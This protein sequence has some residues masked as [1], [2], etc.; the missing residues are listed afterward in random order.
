MI[1]PLI[2][3]VVITALKD[4]Y[5]DIKRHQSDRAV[6]YSQTRVLAG[7]D[8]HNRNATR[9]KSK[10]FVRGFVPKFL[11]PTTKKKR[12]NPGTAQ[13]EMLQRAAPPE[14][15]PTRDP[16]P[17]EQ[18]EFDGIEY[19]DGEAVEGTEHHGLFHLHSSG[20]PRPHWKITTWE[21][22]RVGDVVKILNNEAIPS[23]LL[24]CST[25][26]EENMAFAET[27]NLDGETN[28]K[29]R[30]ACPGLTHLR[31]AGDMADP[32]N[33]FHVDCDR[34]DTNL[35]KMNATVVTND[36]ET[37]T[38]V[39]IQSVMLRGTVLR[40][41]EWVIG[42]VLFTGQDAKIVMNS[43]NTPSKR[44]KVERQMN[45]QVYVVSS[46][47]PECIANV[48]SL[49]FIN[50]LILAVMSIA[51]GI[52]D[53]FLEKH[54]YPLSAYWL[55]GDNQG[56]DN[57]QFN[58]FVTAF[59]SLI[60]FQ[61]IVP[62][63]LYIS[64][65]GV[66][67]VQALF[68]YFDHEMY[69]AK[70]DQ[71]TLSRS[72]NLSDDLGQIEYIFSD[73]TGTLTQN[74]MVFRQCSVGG[75]AYRGDGDDDEVETKYEGS[76]SS[77][78]VDVRLSKASSRSGSQRESGSGS[79]SRPNTG[80]LLQEPRSDPQ[81]VSV[82]TDKL[83]T[84]NPVEAR[85]GVKLS[86]G[87]LKRYRDSILKAD[88][89]AEKAEEPDLDYSPFVSQLNGFWT[90]LA[91]CHTVL[92]SVDPET[93]AIEYKAQ[94]PDEAA[95]VQAAADVGFIFRGRERE[96]L[97][98][99]TPFSDGVEQWELLNVLEFTSSRK[100]MGVVVRRIGGDDKK[101]Y[102]LEKGADNIIFERLVPGNDEMKAITE[103]HLG[104]FAG[105]GLRTLTL[106]YR[107]VPCESIQFAFHIPRI[108]DVID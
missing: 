55:Y 19:D 75:K 25:S 21:D 71:A 49:S 88:L 57:P 2:V 30:S 35:Y 91:L 24:I 79:G 99:S 18:E 98:L 96:V 64:I 43:G 70:T 61:N 80:D 31:T 105:E 82:S 52:I 65:E 36:G 81:S 85:G 53:H 17:Q 101:I 103:Q 46:A 107:I 93:D 37:K 38:G 59:F 54:Y 5:E 41:T 14:G 39:D 78:E 58:G 86:D 108:D 27:K 20:N 26:E 74:Q 84:K 13:M 3:V 4:G 60:T 23:D 87:V 15:I 89:T 100:R 10:T 76:T 40:N 51:L 56:D 16:P 8:F 106:A 66:R 33:A 63:S 42:I 28:L 50:L 68:I 1:L 69:Y 104:E 12:R 90:T 45:P 7:G 92:T 6:N 97:S 32:K 11:K 34:P 29:S 95:L 67:T 62:I 102:L 9:E 83:S 72:W 44:S 73:K 94:S 47:V 48:Y 22:I 77:M